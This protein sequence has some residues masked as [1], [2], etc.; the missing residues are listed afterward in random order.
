MPPPSLP[1]RF[2]GLDDPR[3]RAKVLYPFAEIMLLIQCA[4]LSGAGD[5]VKARVWGLNKLRFLRGIF[6]CARG[7]AAHDT[8]D[9]VM[10][11][12]DGDLFAAAFAA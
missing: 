5:F 12:L 2:S 11:A 4:T 8:R 3:Q 1:D 7:I 6:P 9:D 10:N